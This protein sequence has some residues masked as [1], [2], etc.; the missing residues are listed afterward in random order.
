MAKQDF[1]L[2]YDKQFESDTA[3]LVRLHLSDPNHVITEEEIAAVRVGFAPFADDST[4]RELPETGGR[5]IDR[6]ASR[7]I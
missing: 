5:S 7:R 1:P 2:R 3:K 4:H 6:K